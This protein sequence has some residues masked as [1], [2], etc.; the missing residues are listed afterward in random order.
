MHSRSNT[1]NRHLTSEPVVLT[2]PGQSRV[3]FLK[4]FLLFVFSALFGAATLYF[5]AL[6]APD[7]QFD[8]R[9]AVLED[10]LARVQSE[11]ETTRMDLEIS[12]VARAELERQLAALTEQHKQVREELEFVRSA[13]SPAGR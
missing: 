6:G 12:A 1:A 3:G 10:E 7:I 11:L 5:V 13:G 2:S 8:G 4:L 9:A